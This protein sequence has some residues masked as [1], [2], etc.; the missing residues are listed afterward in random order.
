MYR[1]HYSIESETKTESKLDISRSFDL[2]VI[3]AGPGGLTAAI[4]AAQ[5]G[6]SVLLIEKDF[7]GGRISAIGTVHNY[8]GVRIGISGE[9]LVRLMEKQIKESGIT[10][11]WDEVV[12]IKLIDKHV[13]V[14][15]EKNTIYSSPYAILATGLSPKK[16]GIPGEDKYFGLGVSYFAMADREYFRNKTIAIV[17]GGNYA[18]AQAFSLE[19]I[20][21]KIIIVYRHEDLKGITSFKENIRYNTRYTTKLGYYVEEIYGDQ[22][23]SGLL[24]SQR[25]SGKLERIE[26]DA[27]VVCVG[28]YP[29]TGFIGHLMTLDEKGF[30]LTDETMRTSCDQL[31]AVGDIRSKMIR[32][33]VTASSDGLIASKAIFERY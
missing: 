2:I 8:L 1:N 9:E 28:M 23:I 33:I 16:L 15:T 29:K 19:D 21:E 25:S 6:M 18:L 24:L 27:V 14:C 30:I 5:N 12:D 17:G 20:A 22:M 31:Y 4:G 32:Q 13:F 26:V 11:V 3:G 7:V 10:I